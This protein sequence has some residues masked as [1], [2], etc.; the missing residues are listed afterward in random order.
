MPDRAF[1]ECHDV[2]MEEITLVNPKIII[3]FGNQVSS[4]LLN[5]K[6]KVSES[7]LKKYD[8]KIGKKTYAVYPTYY[9]VGMGFRNVGKAIEDIK[10]IMKSI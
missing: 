5:E 1:K 6:V 3:A 8:L 9:P 10:K 4:N 2:M 7:R